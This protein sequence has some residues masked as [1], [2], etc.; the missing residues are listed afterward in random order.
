MQHKLIQGDGRDLSVLKDESV[1]LVLTSPP[2]WNIKNYGDEKHQL[3]NIDKYEEFLDELDKTWKECLRIL[4]PGGR[5][6]VVV[7]DV[8]LSRKEHGRHHVMPLHSD[9][10]TRCRNIGFDNLAP[11]IWYKISNASHEMDRPGGGFLG[12]PYEPNAIIK[13]DIEYILML[14]KPGKYRSPTDE[15]RQKSKIGKTDFKKW[16]Q[17]IWSDV[18]GATTKSGHPAPFPEELSTRLIRMF[19]FDGDIVVDPFV[20]SGTTVISAIKCNRMGVGMEINEKF[21][22]M[23]HKRISGLPTV[24]FKKQEGNCFVYSSRGIEESFVKLVEQNNAK[25]EEDMEQPAKKTKYVEE[26]FDEDYLPQD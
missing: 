3:G 5:L 1:G 10:Q 6:V 18:Q 13:N 4:L 9:I 26:D 11:I 19:S 23:S 15:Q 12:K 21:I 16:F 14:R 8:L 20:G 17:Q 24:T 2:Y 25:E 22:E 7:G